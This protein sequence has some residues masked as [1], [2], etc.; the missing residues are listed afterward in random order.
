MT[1]Q[2]AKDAQHGP[3]ALTS[4]L[5][6]TLEE[7]RAAL[8]RLH[9]HFDDHLGALRERQQERIAEATDRTN[10][11]ISMLAKLKQARDRK[12]RLL[13]RV[14]RVE[15]PQASVEDLIA[16][17]RSDSHT[18]PAA[19]ELSAMREKV[20]RQAEQTQKRCRDFE[21]TLHYAVNLGRELLQA[22]QGFESQGAGRHYTAKGGAVD[23]S[24]PRSFVNRIG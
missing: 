14:L 1:D 22:A 10:E 7:E 20:R 13:G 19:E 15:K 4:S 2:H 16:S 5:L 17:L 9:D 21:F 12:V 6:E 24:N 3:A 18:A 23:S 11:E 8:V